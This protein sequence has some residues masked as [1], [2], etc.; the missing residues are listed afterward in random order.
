MLRWYRD[1][2]AQVDSV[3]LSG[4]FVDDGLV[5][6]ELVAYAPGSQLA[7]AVASY[8]QTQGGLLDRLP[9]MPYVLAFGS[10]GKSGPTA[11]NEMLSAYL[12]AM[13]QSLPPDTLTEA[14]KTEILRIGN[15]LNEQVTAVQ[16][17][18]GGAPQAGGV[19]S[20]GAVMTCKSAGTTSGLLRDGFR[21][22]EQFVKAVAPPGEAEDFQV[23]YAAGAETVGGIAVDI[24]EFTDPGV[25]EMPDDEKQQMTTV[26]G[27]SKIQLR[28]ASPDERTLVVTFGG[29]DAFMEEALKLAAG[30]GAIPDQVGTQKAMK[31]LPADA[32]GV[33]LLNL[34]NFGTVF[35]QGAQKLGMAQMMPPLNFTAETPIAMG[36]SVAGE[37]S[38]HAVLFVPTE[39]VQDFTQMW[40]MFTM[41]P[42]G[43]GGGPGPGPGPMEGGEDF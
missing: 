28:M 6:E 21:F 16:F 14:D 36:A 30:G 8:Q 18:A 37:S 22:A 33:A 1:M 40:M 23:K 38:I 29:A 10:R 12:D 7:Q 3:M 25:A 2:I 27:E 13:S 11:D 35:Q 20:C 15:G 26:L 31:Y 19:F 4:R 17:V 32:S 41:G 9:D 42:G 39:V 34:Q 24:I 43:P 5:V